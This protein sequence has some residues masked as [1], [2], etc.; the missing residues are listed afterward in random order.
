MTSNSSRRPPARRRPRRPRPRARPRATSPAV[1][2]E[3]AAQQPAAGT[4]RSRRPRARARAGPR[5][6]RVR[7]VDPDAR[8]RL[9]AHELALDLRACPQ[10]RFGRPGD[11]LVE[12]ARRVGRSRPA[13]NSAAPSAGSTSPRAASSTPAGRRVLEQT[14]SRGG[15]AAQQR[16]VRGGR[17][18]LRRRAGQGVLVLAGARRARRGGDRPRPRW[19][20]IVSSSAPGRA[21]IQRA[22]RSCSSAR[23]C[24]RQRPVRGLADRARARTGT[25]PRPGARTAPR[26]S[27]ACG[28]ARRA[29]P[30]AGR[31]PRARPT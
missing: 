19:W 3:L 7:L 9:E 1:P 24:L 28:R 2:G 31:A 22:T 13:S 17:Q 8:L 11:R 12:D 21:S 18:P 23:R 26:G 25:R 20:P 4:A 15:I 27:A 16:G 6:R 10:A 14:R 5:R 30:R 29:R